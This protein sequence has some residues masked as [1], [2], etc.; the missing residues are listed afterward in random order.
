[1]SDCMRYRESIGGIISL[2]LSF[3]PSITGIDKADS[4]LFFLREPTNGAHV[5]VSFISGSRCCK[6]K[7]YLKK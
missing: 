2:F 3:T 1:M 5:S 7:S 6:I 4:M